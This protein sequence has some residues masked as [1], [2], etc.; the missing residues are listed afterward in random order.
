MPKVCFDVPEIKLEKLGKMTIGDLFENLDEEELDTPH[1][2]EDEVVD[3][4]ED[5]HLKKIM[6]DKLS[7]DLAYID[8]HSV[9]RDIVI[10]ARTFLA[11]FSSSGK[12]AT[13]RHE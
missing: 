3:S 11:L 6:P 4:V 8:H 13:N 9:R 10:I 1:Y 7:L 5:V 12:G 2:S